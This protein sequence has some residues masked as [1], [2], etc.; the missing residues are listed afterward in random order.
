MFKAGSQSLYIYVIIVQVSAYITDMG[1]VYE[2][3]ME[4]YIR[5]NQDCPYN[6]AGGFISYSDYGMYTHSI[7]YTVFLF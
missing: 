5:E 3:L 6:E 7:I 4:L 1:S 2:K